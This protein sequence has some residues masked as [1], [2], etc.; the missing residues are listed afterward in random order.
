MLSF[1]C[2]F[3]ALRHFFVTT[4]FTL[5]DGKQSSWVGRALINRAIGRDDFAAAA[6][7]DAAASG[8]FVDID[9]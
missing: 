2:G 6:R 9:A 3:G 5:P 1:A 7:T 8:S 4:A